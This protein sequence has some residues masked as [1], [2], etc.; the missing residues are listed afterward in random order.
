VSELLSS[1][2][3]VIHSCS[4]AHSNSI[5][6]AHY[7]CLYHGSRNVFQH[8]PNVPGIAAAL[9]LFLQY[10]SIAMHVISM[11]QQLTF[12]ARV[13]LR[14]YTLRFLTPEQ[15]ATMQRMYDSVGRHHHHHHHN[16]RAI[17]AVPTE[18][19]GLGPLKSSTAVDMEYLPL[20]QVCTIYSYS[21]LQKYTAT[22]SASDSV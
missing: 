2:C 15:K 9:T 13:L 11:L 7:A 12:Q 4:E 3:L 17:A 16:S 21:L 20:V 10:I 8:M 22:Y 14:A 5:G 1:R 6:F 18:G 19:I